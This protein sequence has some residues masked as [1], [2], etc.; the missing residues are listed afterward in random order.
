MLLLEQQGV[1]GVG[2]VVHDGLVDEALAVQVYHQVGL[3]HGLGQGLEHV[4]G[5]G[6][7]VGDLHVDLCLLC[8]QRPQHVHAV[9]VQAG[10]T[11][12]EHVNAPLPAH[13][14]L[15][16]VNIVADAAGGDDHGICQALDLLAVLANSD[17]AASL[18]LGAGEQLLHGGVEV[19]LNAD[20]TSI[21]GNGLDHNGSAALGG[22]VGAGE[23]DHVLGSLGVLEV[24]EYAQELNALVLHPLYGFAGHIEPTAN[25]LC[26][27]TP[28]GILHEEVEGLVLGVVV[29]HGLLLELGLNSEERHAHVGCAADGAGLLENNN[30]AAAGSVQGLL[31]LGC[32][33][34]AG[35]AAANEYNIGF[36][37]FHLYILLKVFSSVFLL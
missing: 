33:A 13:V 28:V 4:G 19:E 23:L 27:G 37:M 30:G 20:L 2:G 14:L 35:H 15:D 26:I 31:C 24:L 7:V 29:G 32:S 16:H 25:Q 34:E 9:A 17:Y 3:T 10:D 8:T 1:A 12:R 36:N 22:L 18:T 5:A 21:L 11:E 6:G